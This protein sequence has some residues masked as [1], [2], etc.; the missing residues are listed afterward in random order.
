MTELQLVDID[1]MSIKV[2]GPS[3]LL[4]AAVPQGKFVQLSWASYGTQEIAGFSI[5]RREGASALV[6]D[7]CYDGIPA[8]GRI[9]QGWIC[10]RLQHP[11]LY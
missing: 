2:L 1:N 5:Y 3:P 7:T 8:F 10:L 4:T 6:A 9:C 11:H